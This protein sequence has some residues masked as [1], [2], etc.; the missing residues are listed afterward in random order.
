M[1]VDLKQRGLK[2]RAVQVVLPPVIVVRYGPSTQT[3]IDGARDKKGE[4]YQG[5]ANLDRPLSQHAKLMHSVK[6]AASPARGLMY[7]KAPRT[8]TLSQFSL[9]CA[10]TIEVALFGEINDAVI[11]LLVFIICQ[12]QKEVSL[13]NGSASRNAQYIAACPCDLDKAVQDIRRQARGS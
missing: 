4:R 7:Q 2:P 1:I 8:A 3:E 11:S 6:R 5:R 13:R 9:T 12:L 10:A